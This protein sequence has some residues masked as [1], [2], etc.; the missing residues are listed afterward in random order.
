MGLGQF[1]VKITPDLIDGD[2]SNIIGAQVPAATDAPFAVDD[3]L[4][5][6]V[7]MQV[8]KGSNKLVSITGYLMGQ[9]GGEQIDGDIE[10]VFAKSLNGVAP[11]TLGAVNAAQ[12]TCFELPLHF[13][14]FAKC[15]NTSSITRGV[16]FGDFFTSTYGG[17]AGG[18]QLPIVLEGEPSSGQNVGYDVI[19]VAA[20]VIGLVDFSTGVKPD[21]Q[22]TTSTDTISVDGVDPRKC[23][24]IGDTIYTNTND[25]A[26]GTVKSMASDEI[27][28][29]ANLAVQVEDNEEIVNANPV[30]VTFGF[31]K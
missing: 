20:F 7:P 6:W 9:D 3:I 12:T 27:V 22:A 31:E 11:G 14:G 13:V 29:N 26:L 15:E 17:G 19:Y 2:V 10:F 30:R 16:K 28:L 21:A 4:F 1:T 8:P 5:D 18:A 24:Q 23:F 25:T